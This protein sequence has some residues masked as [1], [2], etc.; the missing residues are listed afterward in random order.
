LAVDQAL[1]L[2]GKGMVSADELT[3]LAR[4]F[5]LARTEP[6]LARPPRTDFTR[7]VE[8]FRALKKGMPL[9]EVVPWV[10]DADAD[11]GRGIHVLEYKLADGARVLLG[12]ADFKSLLY[13]KHEKAGKT[14][15][16]V[17]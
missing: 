17:K 12:F 15:D 4:A 8:P 7:T 9:T 6:A 10:G 11:I 16:L 3:R 2:E 13:V 1:V 5:D 14:E